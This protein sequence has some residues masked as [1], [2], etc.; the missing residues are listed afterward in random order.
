MLG[1]WLIQFD[2]LLSFREGLP[3]WVGGWGVCDNVIIVLQSDNRCKT[4]QIV[5]AKLRSAKG[6]TGVLIHFDLFQAGVG[7]DI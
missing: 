3:H 5:D 7:S 4:H 2:F 1:F 6:R